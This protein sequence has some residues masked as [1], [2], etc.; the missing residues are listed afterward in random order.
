MCDSQ[1]FYVYNLPWTMHSVMVWVWCVC[2]CVCVCVRLVG[3]LW[4]CLGES[5]SSSPWT[6]WA[7]L[8]PSKSSQCRPHGLTPT[9]K[10]AIQPRTARHTW[11][12]ILPDTHTNK[13]THTHTHTHTHRIAYTRAFTEKYSKQSPLVTFHHIIQLEFN[14]LSLC[15]LNII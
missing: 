13:H 15:L 12:R 1:H 3:S 5:Q 11:A 9:L 2:V 14:P 10:G 8:P 6:S 4:C 7:L